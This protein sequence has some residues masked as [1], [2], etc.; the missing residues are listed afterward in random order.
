MKDLIKMTAQKIEYWDNGKVAREKI[1]AIIDEV[2]ASIPSIW[3]NW[4]WYIW[5]VDT[6][7]Y[8]VGLKLRE[9]DNLIKKDSNGEAYTDLQFWI[10][11][12]PTS[13]FP[14]WVVVWNVSEDNGWIKSWVLL[15]QKTENSYVRL[16][17]WDDWNT[18]LDWWLGVFKRIAT[19][20]YVDNKLQELRNSLHTVAF[21]GLSSDLDNDY[22]FTAVPI[23]TKEE[24]EEIPWTAS[25]DKEYFLYE[26]VNEE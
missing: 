5:G 6:W 10:D 16:L 19:T 2:N 18:Y 20:E 23:M 8:A 3:P 9:N 1:N 21:T 24:Y 26:V 25:D 14:L 7:I 15:N 22:W 11:L 13:D 17:Y 4:N 12:T